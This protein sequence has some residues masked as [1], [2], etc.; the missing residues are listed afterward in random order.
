M[1]L[2][3]TLVLVGEEA[4]PWC[5]TS[6][7]RCGATSPG[8]SSPA[9][10]PHPICSRHG[11]GRRRR[12]S[13]G[14]EQARARPRLVG[15]RMLGA[16]HASV[17]RRDMD[18]AGILRVGD[19]DLTPLVAPEGV[20]QSVRTE[21]ICASF[22]PSHRLQIKAAASM[23]DSR[24]RFLSG[25]N[26]LGASIEKWGP[27]RR[28]LRARDHNERWVATLSDVSPET[29]EAMFDY[30][31]FTSSQAA[32]GASRLCSAYDGFSFFS[33]LWAKLSL[34]LDMVSV[35]QT[36]SG[37]VSGY[38]KLEL[39]DSKTEALVQW[40]HQ[41]GFISGAAREWVRPGEPSLSVQYGAGAVWATVGN[42]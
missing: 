33:P 4:G 30:R 35:E 24:A 42:I 23:Q 5:L 3:A 41:H 26:S 32:E 31:V 21:W 25:G 6:T 8:I 40:L 12:L 17:V 36:R 15:Q 27:Q 37:E 10:P 38:V 7:A 11:G 14:V 39:E 2:E 20:L 9:W 18:I 22:T 34:P 16:E 13:C 28:F 1:L 29:V 19:I